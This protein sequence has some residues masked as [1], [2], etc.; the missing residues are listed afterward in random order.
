MTDDVKRDAFF[1]SLFGEALARVGVDDSAISSLGEPGIVLFVREPYYHV[2]LHV[3]SVYGAGSTTIEVWKH[4][5]LEKGDLNLWP[6]VVRLY[7]FLLYEVARDPAVAEYI[8]M[9]KMKPPRLTEQM[10]QDV[11]TDDSCP[12]WLRKW[13]FLRMGGV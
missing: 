11:L 9:P 5:S 7:V 3:E 12:G 6:L 13:A 1:K 2:G 4:G 8:T 10:L